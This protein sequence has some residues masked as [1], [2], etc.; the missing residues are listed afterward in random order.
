MSKT[1]SL[2]LVGFGAGMAAAMWISPELRSRVGKTLNDA[3]GMMSDRFSDAMS[4]AQDGV[5]KGEE[6][7]SSV[8]GNLKGS[9][10]NAAGRA[11]DVVDQVSTRSRD[12]IHRAGDYLEQVRA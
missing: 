6:A 2:F 3:S 11:K 4:K 1:L 5:R 7:I 9:I 10:D 12:A 8:T